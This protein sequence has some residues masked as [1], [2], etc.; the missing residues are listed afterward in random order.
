MQ[1]IDVEGRGLGGAVLLDVPVR[2]NALELAALHHGQVLDRFFFHQGNGIG[3]VIVG[4]A[5]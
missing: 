3:K 2:E 4:L 5:W 1:F